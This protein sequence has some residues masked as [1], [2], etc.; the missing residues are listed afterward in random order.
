M[1]TLI[2]EDDF[3]SRTLLQELMKPY[4]ENHVAVNGKEAVTAFRSSMNDGR[5]YDLI[6][7][8]IMMPDMDGQ[9]TL[10]AIREIENE[11]HVS[12]GAGV[13]II[14]TTALGDKDNIF[15]A[16]R[17][18]CDAYMIKPIDKDQLLSHLRELKLI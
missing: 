4:G 5:P 6:C 18:Q 12:P 3:T 16:F 13:K 8:D 1:R 9:Q 10:K 11:R 15:K 2:V 7:L 14:M 17:E